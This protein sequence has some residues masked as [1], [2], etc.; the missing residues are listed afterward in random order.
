MHPPELGPW[1]AC[2]R[3]TG[4]HQKGI[5]PGH[6]S[7]TAPLSPSSTGDCRIIHAHACDSRNLKLVRSICTLVL[8]NIGRNVDSSSTMISQA[9]VGAHCALRLTIV[10]THSKAQL[11]PAHCRTVIPVSL[12]VKDFGHFI[13]VLKHDAVSIADQFMLTSHYALNHQ[14]QSPQPPSSPTLP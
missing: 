6:K 11:V 7:R 4:R 3:Q 12:P 8:H 5:G 13:R 14:A 9:F 2:L 10:R 1:Q